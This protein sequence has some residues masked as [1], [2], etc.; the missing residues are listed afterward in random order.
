MLLNKLFTYKL[1]EG[2]STSLLKFRIIINGNHE[3]FEGHFPGN[4]ITPGVCQ[5]E[6]VKEILSDYFEEALFYRS[7][8]DMKFINM[9]IPDNSELVYL[10]ITTNEFED[11]YKI[12]ASIYTDTRI[13]FKLRGIVNG[14][15]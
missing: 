10:D 3:I 15:F 4:P 8:S 1:L 9:W 11:G 12:K 5:M 7:V 2:D 6:M 13:Y 14:S